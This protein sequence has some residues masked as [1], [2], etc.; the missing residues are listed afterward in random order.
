MNSMNGIQEVLRHNLLDINNQCQGLRQDIAVFVNSVSTTP[1]AMIKT[2]LSA[3][4][5]RIMMQA[6]HLHNIHDWKGVVFVMMSDMILRIQWAEKEF[7][8]EVKENSKRNGYPILSTEEIVTIV[9]HLADKIDSG[10]WAEA[11]EWINRYE[12]FTLLNDKKLF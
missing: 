5:I 7:P 1:A 10:Q 8:I 11:V 9:E 12:T 4:S 2:R 6:S 3:M